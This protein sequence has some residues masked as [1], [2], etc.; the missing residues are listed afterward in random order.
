MGT[1]FRARAAGWLAG[2]GAAA[3][4]GAAQA[5]ETAPQRNATLLAGSTP[6]PSHVSYLQYGLSFTAELVASP[7][8]MCDD[9]FA[10]EQG[11]GPRPPPV[12]IF[13]GGGGV[14]FRMGVRGTGPWYFGG[15]YEI[16]KQDSTK[17]YRL[18]ILQQIR[19]EARYYVDT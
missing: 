10:P 14:A 17:L 18:A 5:D 6:P 11:L 9:A 15:A 12:C 7:G 2:F 4:A 13:G 1:A 19:G 16:S 3:L 8:P